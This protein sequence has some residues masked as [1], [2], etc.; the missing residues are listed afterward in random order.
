MVPWA[1]YKPETNLQISSK[2]TVRKFNTVYSFL[3]TFNLV[4][5]RVTVSFKYTI[6]QQRVEN[7]VNQYL[8]LQSYKSVIQLNLQLLKILNV[9]FK[10]FQYLRWEKSFQSALVISN[11]LSIFPWICLYC[12][13]TSTI[14]AREWKCIL[15]M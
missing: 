15:I 13:D 6:N 14:I 4:Y 2:I 9:A 12:Y 7:W 10:I 5:S 11:Q 3:L 8:H 1:C